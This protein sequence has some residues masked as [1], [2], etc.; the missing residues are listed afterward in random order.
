MKEKLTVRLFALQKKLEQISIN[1]SENGSILFKYSIEFEL[2]LDNLLKYDYT[3][4][5]IVFN[6][7]NLRTQKPCELVCEFNE[8]KNRQEAF[9]SGINEMDLYIKQCLK[10]LTE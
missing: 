6:N 9:S 2:L 8:E 1:N 4:F 3:K 7:Y 10:I 5:Y